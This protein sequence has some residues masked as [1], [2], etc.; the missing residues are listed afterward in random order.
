MRF[1]IEAKTTAECEEYLKIVYQDE[2]YRLEEFSSK[3]KKYEF[4]L[5]NLISECGFIYRGKNISF[6]DYVKDRKEFS[7][8][9]PFYRK[10]H[11]EL[12][13][14]EIHLSISSLAYYRAAKFLEK[15]EEC[16]QTARYY[17][18][19]SE[20]ILEYDC[21]VNWTSGYPAIYSIRSMNFST[22]IIWYNNCF[23]YMIQIAFLAFELYKG[24]R[25]YDESIPFEE[26]LK[27]CTY[28]ALKTL[29]D[30]DKSNQ[31]L[32]NLWNIVE[33]C[34]SSIQILN[35]W[36]NYSKHKGGLSFIGLK[37]VSPVMVYIQDS[38]GNKEKRNDELDA[39]LI[40]IDKDIWHV[41]SAH[42]ALID[43]L[44]E[45][46]DIIDFPHAVYHIDEKGRYVVPD[47]S[48]Y[49]KVRL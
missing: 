45:L 10:Y 44:N 5:D 30:N 32:T 35:D 8:R 37:P 26:V 29:H 1:K 21:C 38:D 42:N 23:D 40:D 7:E 43:C 27:M 48:Q 49:C 36:A 13:P 3:Y 39:V 22:A 17:L 31:G 2:V 6:A 25:R 41:V 19:K 20:D 47:K 15:A 4:D 18:L 11:D 9:L 12:L 46:V 24:I 16:L 14:I 34:R 28:N 33:K